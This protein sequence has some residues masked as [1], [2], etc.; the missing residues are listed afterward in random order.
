[1]KSSVGEPLCVRLLVREQSVAFAKELNKLNNKLS[2]MEP[3][4]EEGD[5][6]EIEEEKPGNGLPDTG[7]V[8]TQRL[9]L[10]HE[11]LSSTGG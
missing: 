6:K 9:R 3:D 2:F 5:G 11:N 10:A 1:M 4:D 8:S 7:R